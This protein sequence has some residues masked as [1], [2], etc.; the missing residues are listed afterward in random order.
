[1]RCRLLREGWYVI[2]PL[3][4]INAL[5][6][7]QIGISTLPASRNGRAVE[8]HQQVMTGSTL[9]KIEAIVHIHLIVAGEEVDLHTSHTDLL[10]PGE[11]LL[12]VFG[13]VQAVF[14]RRSAIHPTNTGVI[15][16]H[17]FHAFLLGIVHG[18]LYGLAIFHTIPLC[19]DEHIGQMERGSHVDIL[20]DDVVIVRTMIISPIDPRYHTWMNPASIRQ[21]A[22][23]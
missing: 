14:G 3:C 8:I 21:P 10:T 9:Q 1:M 17:R 2:I 19:I 22:R 6:R 7:H 18:I 11:F 15:P 12:T 16:D 5:R 23:L 13:L 4:S 20:T